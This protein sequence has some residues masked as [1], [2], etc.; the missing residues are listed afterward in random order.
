MG[1]LSAVLLPLALCLTSCTT[2]AYDLMETGSIPAKFADSDPQDFGANAP[3]R[4]PVH[5]IDVSKY[6]G[7]VDWQKARAHGVSFAFIK[8]TEGGDRVDP[9]FDEYW[10]EARAA[11]VPYAPYHFYYFC[12]PPAEQ[13]AWFIRNV[14]RDAVMMPPVIDMEWNA[15]SP[16]CKIRPEAAFVRRDLKIFSDALERHYGKKPII[17]TTIDFHRENLKGHFQDQPFWLRSVANHP[18]KAFGGR[19]W[20]FWQYTGT[21]IV[22]GVRGQADINVFAGNRSQWQTWLASTVAAR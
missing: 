20:T 14:P 17:Y 2:T 3:S 11:G 13:A 5:G 8:A 7:D 10:H 16:T 15:A 21:G 12:T 6:Q 1:C 22:P 19:K 18:D 9:K 4:Y